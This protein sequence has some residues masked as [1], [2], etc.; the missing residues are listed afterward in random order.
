MTWTR[1]VLHK[2]EWGMLTTKIK[3]LGKNILCS[4]SPQPFYVADL[5]HIRCHEPAFLCK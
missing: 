5:L 4:F 2:I 3:Q 1:H